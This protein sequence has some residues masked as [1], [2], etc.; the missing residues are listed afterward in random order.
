MLFYLQ[1][2]ISIATKTITHL[3]NNSTEAIIPLIIITNKA[4]IL[5]INNIAEAIYSLINIK[6]QT[7]TSVN[8]S[9]RI[10]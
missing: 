8:I 4:I 9:Q 1:L 7:I 2:I 5:F 3:I 10:Q 6:I